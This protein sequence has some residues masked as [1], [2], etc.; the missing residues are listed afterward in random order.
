LF[1]FAAKIKSA[2]EWY[3]GGVYPELVEGL[4]TSSEKYRRAQEIAVKL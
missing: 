2:T 3:F 1:F 4:S